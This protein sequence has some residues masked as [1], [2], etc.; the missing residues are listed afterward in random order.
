MRAA[1]RVSLQDELCLAVPEEPPGDVSCEALSARSLRVRWAP[2][3]AAHA[4]ALRGYDLHYTPLHFATCKLVLGTIV[5][6]NRTLFIILM[7]RL[8]QRGVR[9]ARHKRRARGW[10]A[11]QRC[12][13]FAAPPTTRCGCVH[14]P[15]P[16]SA[17]P[18]LPSTAP[19]RTTVSD[20]MLKQKRPQFKNYQPLK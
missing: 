7:V 15:T 1:R 16:G 18:R 13:G 11:K 10:V 19:P 5:C 14:A 2:L 17:R 3:S 12:R 9:R 20:V 4:H 6:T 8:T